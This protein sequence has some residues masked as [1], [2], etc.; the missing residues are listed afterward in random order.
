MSARSAF[1]KGQKRP[2]DETGSGGEGLDR[3]PEVKAGLDAHLKQWQFAALLII[4]PT[5]LLVSLKQKG[6]VLKLWA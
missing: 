2:Q 5:C 4:G 3:N 1:L 6:I